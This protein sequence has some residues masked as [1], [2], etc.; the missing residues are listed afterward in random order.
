MDIT[1]CLYFVDR[2][3]NSEALWYPFQN[4]AS[5]V[6]ILYKGK[7]GATFSVESDLVKFASQERRTTVRLILSCAKVNYPHVQRV[8]NNRHWIKRIVEKVQLQR[9]S[10]YHK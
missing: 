7:L 1:E 5:R 4:S 2:C 3:K 8:G 6:T 9:A 10:T